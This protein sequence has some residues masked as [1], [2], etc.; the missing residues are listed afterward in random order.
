MTSYVWISEVHLQAEANYQTAQNRMVSW[1]LPWQ[2]K[3]LIHHAVTL[4]L[5]VQQAS[6]VGSLKLSVE[7]FFSITSDSGITFLMADLFFQP[8]SSEMDNAGL[9]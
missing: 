1:A 7:C 9:K 4:S 8:W 5:H 3:T 6:R 2:S